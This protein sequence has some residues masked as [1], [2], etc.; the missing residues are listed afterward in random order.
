MK[1]YFKLYRV[2]FV[3]IFSIFSL[4]CA[5][6][7]ETGKKLWGSSTEAL[8]RRKDQGAIRAF[9]CS[10]PDCFSASLDILETMKARVFK[11]DKKAGYIIAINFKNATDTTEVGLFFNNLKSNI[12]SVEIISLNSRLQDIASVQIFSKLNEKFKAV[13]ISLYRKNN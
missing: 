2:V 9:Q 5:N 7:Q 1:R 8:E 4:S 6:L 13:D 11:K 3:C 12:A 10:S